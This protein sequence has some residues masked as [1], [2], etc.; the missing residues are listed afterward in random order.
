MKKDKKFFNKKTVELREEEIVFTLSTDT[1]SITKI[2]IN[3]G[4]QI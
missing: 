1:T 3:K 4:E 2:I